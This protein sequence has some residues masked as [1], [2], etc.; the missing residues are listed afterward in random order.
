[1]TT[2]QRFD[3]PSFLAGLFKEAE[4]QPH[5]PTDKPA[6][7][8]TPAELPMDWRIA[9]EERSGILEY[10]GGHSRDIAETMALREI[11]ARMQ[12]LG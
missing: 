6:A 1:M 9:W 12:A 2:S 5:C 8:I 4:I 10:D 11:V 7:A 3:A